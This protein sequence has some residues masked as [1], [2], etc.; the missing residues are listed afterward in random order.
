MSG[1]GMS[2]VEA[3]ADRPAHYL[4][5]F[6]VQIVEDV[7]VNKRPTPRRLTRRVDQSAECSWSCGRPAVNTWSLAALFKTDCQRSRLGGIARSNCRPDR[8]SSISAPR[9]QVLPAQ[10]PRARPCFADHYGQCRCRRSAG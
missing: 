3:K 7:V 4:S 6:G 8:G 9:F 2:V 5:L 10:D 1:Y